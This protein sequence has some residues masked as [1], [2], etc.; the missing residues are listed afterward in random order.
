MGQTS[1]AVYPA[2]ETG[3]AEYG[4][5]SEWQRECIPLYIPLL[6]ARYGRIF[7]LREFYMM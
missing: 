5:E 4:W 2:S 7:V 6:A 3:E 1:E